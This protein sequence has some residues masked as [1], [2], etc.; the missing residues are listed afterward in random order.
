[1]CTSELTRH[2]TQSAA[3]KRVNLGRVHVVAGEPLH[4]RDTD[5]LDW[6]EVADTV[7]Q[8]QAEAVVATQYHITATS[9]LLG[10]AP[11]VIHSVYKS[12]GVPFI[13]GTK[14]P[15]QNDL[16]MDSQLIATLQFGHKF[17]TLFQ[18]DRPDWAR[19]FWTH[20]S[21]SENSANNCE[22]K[23]FV[24][25]L[26][27]LL[28]QADEY[29]RRGRS[30]LIAQG[31][32]EPYDRHVAQVAVV[33]GYDGPR[34]LLN[35]SIL[36]SFHNESMPVDGNSWE[37]AP[38]IQTKRI[39][40]N[41]E[42]LGFWG[43][44]DTKFVV[45]MDSGRSPYV[46]LESKQKKHKPKRITGLLSFMTN[47]LGVEI[48][49]S[50]EA[51]T[52]RKPTPVHARPRFSDADL[53][54]L[55]VLSIKV[56]T[57]ESERLRHGTGHCH[58]D[59]FSIRN[60]EEFRIPDGVIWPSSE[61][62][63]QAAIKLASEKSWCL[64][65]FGG[66]TNVSGATRCPSL[67]VEPRPI[68]AMDMRLMDQILWVNE[69]DMVARVQS[70][71]TGSALAEK[72]KTL[73]FT[74]GHEPD[75]LEFSTL[76]GWIATKASGMKRSKYGNIEDIVL[77]VTAVGSAGVLNHG[78]DERS[79]WERE[80]CNFDIRSIFLGSEGCLG[81]VT[82]AI[83]RLW[84][85][86]E[87]ID[88]DSAVLHDFETAMLVARE[89]S[90]LG[91]LVP[92][93]VRILDNP[94]FRLAQALK[95]AS[96][97]SLQN[98][99]SLFGKILLSSSGFVADEM[100]CITIGYEGSRQAVESQRLSTNRLLSKYSAVQLGSDLGRSAYDAT[101]TIGYLR[102]FA[103]TYHLIGESFE[104]FVPW[105]KVESVIDRVRERIRAEHGSRMLPGRP[106]V[107]A[108]IT[109]LYPT[110]ACI[111]FYFCLS[112]KGIHGANEVYSDIEH[113]ARSEILA[114]GGSLSHHHGI[115][116]IRSPFLTE[117]GT[118]A[119]LKTIKQIK[120]GLD[121][122]NIFAARNGYFAIE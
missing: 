99:R 108:R 48:D 31:F 113:A 102:D 85:I 107:G 37:I 114:V 6:N 4:L 94:H 118:P 39:V 29:T 96:G 32:T 10:L 89:L 13:E 54:E 8:R 83:V 101:F 79:A 7:Q 17:A 80:S 51:F 122:D 18:Q 33:L 121:P 106:F 72:L 50:Q 38:S 5:S 76:G 53:D 86:P 28:D 119:V 41:G 61:S 43:H 25:A 36:R 71:I 82:S 120:H 26:A 95:P 66:G 69:E 27:R 115:G 47:E 111:Y 62:E 74:I 78:R 97:T 57:D 110:G 58:Q 87:C 103:L 105:S 59:I 92:A 68:L 35:S 91:E 42:E 11:D 88:F 3:E 23:S 34:V 73:G 67:L 52:N 55:K 1:M 20:V 109:Q 70:G 60:Q 81:V 14:L 24:T 77:G 21:S 9:S 19:W 116:K 44:H 98:L 16:E 90:K 56:S 49:V 84:P 40:G 104:S 112:F 46:V 117:V 100:V 65:P 64:I 45:K 63:V 12:L 75:S 2:L 30:S 22:R 15:D 93:S